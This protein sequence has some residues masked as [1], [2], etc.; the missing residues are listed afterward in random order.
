MLQ[1]VNLHSICSVSRNDLKSTIFWLVIELE[2]LF[3][4]FMEVYSCVIKWD[5]R[6]TNY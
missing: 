6:N 4:R 3:K 1:F 2:T 5:V